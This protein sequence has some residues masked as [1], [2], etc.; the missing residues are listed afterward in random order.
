MH[1]KIH[2]KKVTVITSKKGTRTGDIIKVNFTLILDV[3]IF[4][5]NAYIMCNY[6]SSLK[7][8]TLPVR[9]SPLILLHS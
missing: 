5:K 4:Y 1:L 8:S 7:T 3:L 6:I 2:I 9:I